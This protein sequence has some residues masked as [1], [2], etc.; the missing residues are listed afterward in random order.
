M[1]RVKFL[2]CPGQPVEEFAEF[3]AS[4]G[5]EDVEPIPDLLN[6]RPGKKWLFSISRVQLTPRDEQWRYGNHRAH[7]EID[8]IAEILPELSPEGEQSMSG[9]GSATVDWQI[10]SVANDDLQCTGATGGPVAVPVEFN[11]R[12]EWWSASRP[13]FILLEVILKSYEAPPVADHGIIQCR[14]YGPDSDWYDVE[15]GIAYVRLIIF[16]AFP[17]V[18]FSGSWEYPYGLKTP[19]SPIWFIYLSS[20]PSFTS[21]E[22]ITLS[23][24]EE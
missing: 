21:T 17:C 10:E 22:N 1:V 13:P 8:T 14:G 7:A 9:Y 12:M 3:I 18:P 4:E 5:C 11:G 6:Y 16:D 2:D 20:Y 24:L 23:V 15:V 19:D